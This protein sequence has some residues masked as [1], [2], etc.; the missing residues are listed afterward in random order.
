M[1][2]LLNFSQQRNSVVKCQQ[3]SKHLTDEHRYILL[4]FWDRLEDHTQGFRQ[5]EAYQE[6]KALLHH[7]Y[8]PFPTVE[9]Y[10][11]CMFMKIKE[12]PLAK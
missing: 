9:Y 11:P 1:P 3:P 8:D 12:P 10:E 5:S 4:I 7:F 2:C 6:W